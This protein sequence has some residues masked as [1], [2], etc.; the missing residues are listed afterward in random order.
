MRALLQSLGHRRETAAAPIEVDG[1]TEHVGSPGMFEQPTH[2]QGMVCPH[3]DLIA[4][5]EECLDGE[6]PQQAGDEIDIGERK[7]HVD[8]GAQVR[9]EPLHLLNRGKR[10]GCLGGDEVGIEACTTSRGPLGML[11][12][13]PCELVGIGQP[14]AC[15]GAHGV[16]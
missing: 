16:E 6:G 15:E 7:R 5:P 12:L 2:L 9:P 10:D 11:A 13:E 14:R 1:H 8:R 3:G 4:L